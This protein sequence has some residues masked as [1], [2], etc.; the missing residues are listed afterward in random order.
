[1]MKISKNL[2]IINRNKKLSQ[3]VLYSSLSLLLIGFLWSFSNPDATQTLMAYFIL[4][5]AY[6]LVQIS[7]YMANKWGRSPRPDEIVD[8]SLKGLSDQYA[9]Y[10]F[11]TPIPHVLIGP[12]GLWIIKPYHYSGEI[13]FNPDR[14]KFEQIGGPNIISKLF[15]QESLPNIEKESHNL[16]LKFSSYLSSLNLDDFKNEVKVVNIFFSDKAQVR[17]R[18]APEATIHA[19][20]LK[21]FIRNQ[22]KTI[23][24]SNEQLSKIKSV[25]PVLQK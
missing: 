2:K 9:L 19:D 22:A 7:I 17:T 16:I 18:S 11:T 13:I 14:N 23:N 21:E 24:L 10:H 12:A 3:I 20:K 4:I 1:M 6:I 25:F 8:Q 15:A 5:P